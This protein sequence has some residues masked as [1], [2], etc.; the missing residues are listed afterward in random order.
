MLPASGFNVHGAD[1][2][3]GVAYVSSEHHIGKHKMMLPRDHVSQ[4]GLLFVSL[5]ILIKGRRAGGKAD[6]ER[7]TK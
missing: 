2:E 3:R 1:P 5:Q 4:R 7:G 6:K